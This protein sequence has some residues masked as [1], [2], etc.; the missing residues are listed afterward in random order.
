MRLHELLSRLENIRDTMESTFRNE[1]LKG[2]IE[3]LI[4]E[5]KEASPEV[6]ETKEK[7]AIPTS[8]YSPPNPTWTPLYPSPPLSPSYPPSGTPWITYTS[9]TGTGGDLIL[10]GSRTT[11]SLTS[12]DLSNYTIS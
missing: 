12:A 7:E 10:T 8:P 1:F 3:N 4:E 9:G 6:A 11:G 5:L 2:E